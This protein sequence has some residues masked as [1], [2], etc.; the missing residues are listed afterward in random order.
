MNSSSLLGIAT[1]SYLALGLAHLYQ[2]FFKRRKASPMLFNGAV[3]A[4]VLNLAGWIVR[5][6]EA[7]QTGYGYVP[8]SNLYEALISL[9]WCTVVVYIILEKKYKTGFLG[10]FIFPLV[11]LAMAY[12]SFSPRV[13]TA[14]QPLIPALQSNWLTYHVLTC[15]LGYA[16]FTASFGASIMYLVKTGKKTKPGEKQALP[17]PDAD[18]LDEVL[19][20]ANAAGF[21]LLGIGI[22][23]GSVWASRAWGSYWSWDPKET[24]SLITWIIYAVFLHARYARGMRGRTAAVFS[25]IGF[26]AVLFTFLGV[27]YLLSGLHSYA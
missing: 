15:F 17:L 16:A 7:S 19:Y 10:I 5:W 8:L 25:I 24:W 23:T 12:A 20:K 27:N 11:S 13:E 3:G 6:H 26:I 18:I 22:I 2:F 14:I 4:V 9:S 1:F 21:L